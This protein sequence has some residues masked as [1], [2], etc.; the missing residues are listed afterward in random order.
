M[1][2]FGLARGETPWGRVSV[3]IKTVNNRYLKTTI[4]LPETLSS[5]EPVVD[6]VI[7]RDFRRG[8]VNV[9]VRRE[10]ADGTGNVFTLNLAQ[11]EQYTNSLSQFARRRGEG[12]RI[13]LGSLAQLPGVIESA[14]TIH[15]PPEQLQAALH[16]ALERACVACISM[17]EAEGAAIT[18]DLNAHCEVL[19]ALTR[20]IATRGPVVVIEYRNKLRNRISTLLE[21]SGT[22]LREEDLARECAF[23]A[24]RGDIS[25]EVQRL[26]HHAA[27]MKMSLAAGGEIGRKL[28]FIAQEMLREANTMGSKSADAELV[29]YVIDMKSTIEKI[30][31]QVQNIE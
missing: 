11:V 7:R 5:L 18:K 21:G 14:D 16:D 26:D 4:R 20:E 23:Y 13:D 19:V 17:R 1:T 25:E 28:D 29:G 2:G 3:E 27:S 30:K 9:T 22:T 6:A 31:E 24:D 10:L 12:T 15:E 8:T